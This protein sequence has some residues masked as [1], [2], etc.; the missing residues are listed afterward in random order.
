MIKSRNKYF[1][2]SYKLK[3]HKNN[4]SK[5]WFVNVYDSSYMNAVNRVI[6]AHTNH[7]VEHVI[8]DRVVWH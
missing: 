3:Y 8:I 1:Q 5:A 4:T 2:I 6:K 7:T